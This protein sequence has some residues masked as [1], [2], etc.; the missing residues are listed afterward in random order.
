MSGA[1][2]N[3]NHQVT[4]DKFLLRYDPYAKQEPLRFDLR[5]YAAYVKKNNLTASDV[6][7]EILAVFSRKGVGSLNES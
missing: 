2:S 1:K 4:V 7:P 3:Y 5:G 6:T